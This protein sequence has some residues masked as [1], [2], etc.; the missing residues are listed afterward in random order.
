MSPANLSSSTIGDEIVSVGLGRAFAVAGKDRSA[1]IP[2]GHLGKAWWFSEKTGGFT[3]STYYGDSLPAWLMAWN[4]TKPADAWRNVPWKPLGDPNTYA[5]L[6]AANEHARPHEVLGRAFPHPLVAKSDALFYAGFRYTPFLDALTAQCAQQLII[7]EKLGQGK[8]IDYLSISFS[9][10]DYIG[11]CYGPESMEYEDSLRRLDATL[12]ELFAFLDKSIGLDHVLIVLSADH[13]VD[14][15]PEAARARGYAADRIYPDKLKDAANA[16][17]RQ[18]LGISA[19]LVVAFVPP[20]FYLD[21]A[22]LVALK[23]DPAAIENALA[24]HL[25][26]VPG[27]AHA[28]TRTALLAG[29]VPATDLGAKVQRSFHPTRSG[30]VV[31][32]QEQF[33]YLYPKAE[34]FAAMHGSPYSY[35]TFVPVIL[36]GPGITAGRRDDAVSP[37]QIA[38]TLTSFLGIKPPSGAAANRLLPVNA[39]FP[40]GKPD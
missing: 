28:F 18:K 39:T 26:S 15:I 36:C 32:V 23:L 30:D 5:H 40:D 29:M 34:E 31:I 35:D 13:G 33:W 11:H 3:A 25:R 8:S 4:A 10:H 2:G 22:R 27:V 16:A 37:A 21:Q 1:I 7:A 19:D 6:S 20:G 14:D 24:E 12:G 38:P 17:L 9:G